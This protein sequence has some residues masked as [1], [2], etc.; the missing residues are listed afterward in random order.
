MG[1]SRWGGVAAL[2]GLLAHGKVFRC[3]FC[4]IGKGQ[5]ETESAFISI[6]RECAC[7]LDGEGQAFDGDR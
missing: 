2:L 4:A 7:R 5:D 1:A 6:R 3:G